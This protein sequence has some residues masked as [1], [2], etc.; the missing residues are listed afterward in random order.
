MAVNKKNESKL[1]VGRYPGFIRIIGGKWRNRKLPVVIHDGLRPT[2]NRIRETIFNWL[3]PWLPGARCL[4]VTAGTGSL[5][6]E[7]LSQGANSAVMVEQA[8]EAVK[9]L[10]SNVMR[11]DAQ[12]AEVIQ[13]NVV[14]YLLGPARPFDIVFLDPPFKSDLI[15]KCALLLNERGWLKPGSLIYIE[16]PGHLDQLPIPDDWELIRSKVAGQVGYHLARKI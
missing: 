9:M 2:P 11:L 5:C 16:A 7:A 15:A 1:G 13:T 6:L 3:R 14:D 12:D 4:D 10:R 8:P